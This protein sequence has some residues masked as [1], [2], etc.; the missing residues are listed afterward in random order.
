MAIGSDPEVGVTFGKWGDLTEEQ[1]QAWY[2]YIRN[3]WGDTILAGYATIV[4]PD[5]T[6]EDE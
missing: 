1:Q 4:Y 6:P 5:R 3:K 2:E